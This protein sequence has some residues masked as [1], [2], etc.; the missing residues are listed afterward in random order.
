MSSLLLRLSAPLQ[1]WGSSSKFNRRMTNR[2]P[3]KSGVIGLVAAALGRRRSEAIDDLQSLKY[4]VRIDQ[5]GI[6][7]KDFHTAKYW[8]DKNSFDNKKTFISDRYYLADALFIVGL[9]GEDILL[10][11]I[12]AAVKNPAFPLYLGRR[13]CPPVGQVSLG[14]R[15]G[16]SLLEALRDESWHASDWYKKQAPPEVSLEIVYDA[17]PQDVGAYTLRDIPVS[18]SLVHR[19][20]AFRSVMNVID[21]NRLPN[22]ASRYARYQESTTEHDPMVGLIQLSKEGD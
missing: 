13:S 9:E 20:Y 19:K 14:I 7:I 17:E 2:E 18:F 5:T 22:P 15:E 11:E 21:G 1:S 4:G 12:E 6:L 16:K 3:T 8:F 10:Q